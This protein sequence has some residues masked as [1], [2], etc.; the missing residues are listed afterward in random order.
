MY[1]DIFGPVLRETNTRVHERRKITFK[2]V[3][4][5]SVIAPFHP[6]VC[7]RREHFDNLTEYFIESY[8]GQLDPTFVTKYF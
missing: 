1:N 3:Q 5:I 2:H 7:Q 8:V 4:I 6:T